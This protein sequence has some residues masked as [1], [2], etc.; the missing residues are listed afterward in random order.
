MSD[1]IE[2]RTWGGLIFRGVI[3]ILFGIAVFA[4]PGAA[5][6]GLVYLFGVFAILDGI[7]A[8]VAG[9][10]LAQMGGRWWPMFLAGI[11]GITIGVVAFARPAVTAV[12]LVAYVA[13]W[14]I[15]TG[16]AEVVAA[17]RLR[18]VL[19]GEWTL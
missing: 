19:P 5:A 9:G 2:S 16:I 7:F 1:R 10:R 14:A 6:T 17:Y 15:L 4:R 3:A 8:L 13:A 12:G 18:K 11:V